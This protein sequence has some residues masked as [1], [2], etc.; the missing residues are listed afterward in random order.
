MGELSIYEKLEKIQNELNVP[1]GQ[2]NSY[3]EFWYR[4]CEDILTALKPLCEKY[5]VVLTIRDEVTEIAGKNY[6][7][8]ITELHDLDGL[9]IIRNYA[10]AREAETKKGMDASQITGATSSYA[11]KYA[12]NGLFCLDDV[13]DPDTDGF[14]KMQQGNDNPKATD[15]Q[16][17]LIQ[18]MYEDDVEY[19]KEI[20][21]NLNKTKVSELT[22]K[23]ASDIISKKKG[24]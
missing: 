21:S 22:V 10:F 9:E 11:R 14:A 8:A 1:K 20:L 6:I 7:K 17:K 23:E 5:R 3:G 18:N 2:Y 13:K 4:S 19:L 12:L 24:I 16:L 15:K